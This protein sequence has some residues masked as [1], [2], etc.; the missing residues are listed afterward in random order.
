[1]FGTIIHIVAKH[2]INR[3][4]YKKNWKLKMQI[5]VL[6]VFNYYKKEK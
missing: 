6:L 3:T 2:R 4:Q 5:E 1:M